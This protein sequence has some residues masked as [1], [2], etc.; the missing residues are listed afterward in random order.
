MEK[1]GLGLSG[2]F[3]S[4]EESLN[5]ILGRWRRVVE[6]FSE[7]AACSCTEHRVLQAKGEEYWNSFAG[8]TRRID[9]LAQ[10][11]HFVTVNGVVR[12]IGVAVGARWMHFVTAGDDRVCPKCMRYAQGGRGGYYRTNWFLPKIPCHFGDRCL[13]ELVLYDPFDED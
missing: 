2:D 3:S 10:D 7:A 5:E 13:W 1:R 9:G 12:V 6:G 11:L 8:I 4:L